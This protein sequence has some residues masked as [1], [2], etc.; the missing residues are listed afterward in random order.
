MPLTNFSALHNCLVN[1]GVYDILV[2]KM[3]AHYLQNTNASLHVSKCTYYA[4]E[5]N[6]LR[7]DLASY[8]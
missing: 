2:I 1:Y 5:A 3:F 7:V 6:Y 8:V 4:H